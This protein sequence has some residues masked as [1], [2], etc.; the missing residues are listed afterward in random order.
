M[1]A[2]DVIGVTPLLRMTSCEPE[3]A[4]GTDDVPTGSGLL[5]SS[6]LRLKIPPQLA[7]RHINFL[8]LQRRTP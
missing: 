3:I 6:H 4:I 1:K 8:I 2:F 5:T 7:P